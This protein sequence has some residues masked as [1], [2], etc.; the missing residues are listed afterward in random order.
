MDRDIR[1]S[2]KRAGKGNE[3]FIFRLYGD[4]R[5]RRRATFNETSSL[6]LEIRERRRAVNVERAMKST[7]RESSSSETLDGTRMERTEKQSGSSVVGNRCRGHGRKRKKE[8]HAC[9]EIEFETE[10]FEDTSDSWGDWFRSENFQRDKK[11]FFEE[12]G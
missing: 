12:R 6:P 5:A 9:R 3:H 4:N 8:K 11:D 2:C 7:I 1:E 10:K